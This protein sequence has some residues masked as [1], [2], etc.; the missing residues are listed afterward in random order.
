MDNNQSKISPC[1]HSPTSCVFSVVKRVIGIVFNLKSYL[2]LT[3][4]RYTPAEWIA[5]VTRNT[6][7]NRAVINDITNCVWAATSST[8]VATFLVN[9]SQ[10]ALTFR[11]D[12][13]FGA[14]IWRNTDIVLQA[15]ARRTFATDFTY[16]VRTT[17]IRDTRFGFRFCWNKKV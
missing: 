10:M 13:T 5:S 9:A 15:R 1:L 4:Y 12:S 17:R 16:R 2:A 7:A 6:G 11:I 8:H 14:T 3:W